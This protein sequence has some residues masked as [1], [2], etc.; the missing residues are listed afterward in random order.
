[1]IAQWDS[2]LE[3]SAVIWLFPVV[4]MLHDLEEIITVEKWLATNKKRVMNGLPAGLVRFLE[5]S[6]RM[7][8]AQFAAAV[9]CLFVILS[10]ATLLAAVTLPEGTYLPV[11]LVCLHVLFLNVFSHLGHTLQFRCYTPGVVTAVLVVLPYAL[12]AYYRLLASGA[13]TWGTLFATL[14]CV[15]FIG[16]V[17]FAAHWIGQKA[18]RSAPM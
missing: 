16:P 7:T 18:V 15:L 12:Y 9:T 14:P 11:F 10:L 2:L 3:L 17:L 8:T 4:F 6:L 1:M 13:V 5:P